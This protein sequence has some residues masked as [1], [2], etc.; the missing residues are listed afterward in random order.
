[1][2]IS[3]IALLTCILAVTAAI[4]PALAQVSDRRFEIGAQAA[5]LRL[6]DFGGFS[7]GIGGRGSFDS[8]RWVAVDAEFNFYPK[9][10]MTVSSTNVGDGTLRTVYHR[11]RA[12]AFFG[13]KLGHR[14]DRF[15]TFARVRPGFANLSNKGVECVGHVCS[16]ALFLLAVPEYRTEFALDLGGTFEF[17][18]S[19]RVVARVDLGDLMIRHRGYAPPCPACT[20]HNFTSRL[21][22]GW[23]F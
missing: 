22:I 13:A 12:D 1:M 14:G 21:G 19:P 10:D 8:S 20:T 16:L 2:T 5:V 11:R 17:Y 7:A 23:R 4:S 3:R 6:S 18:P 9:D 15:G